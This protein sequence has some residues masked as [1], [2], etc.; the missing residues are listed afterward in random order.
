MW[1]KTSWEGSWILTMYFTFPL[2]HF[3]EHLIRYRDGGDSKVSFG[4]ITKMELETKTLTDDT[5]EAFH[6]LL[7]F[8]KWLWINM[9]THKHVSMIPDRGCVQLKKQFIQ[10]MKIQS[11]FTHPEVQTILIELFFSMKEEKIRYFEEL[12]WL[13]FFMQW[14]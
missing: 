7:L 2:T 13:L 9:F 11:L 12:Y 8:L 5:N 4:T 10:I 14:Q 3:M 1:L 6:S